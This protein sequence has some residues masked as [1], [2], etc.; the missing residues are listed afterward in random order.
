MSTL[1]VFIFKHHIEKGVKTKFQVAIAELPDGTP[2]NIPVMV[3]RGQR[4]GPT[5]CLSGAI[6]GDEY[7]GVAVISRLLKQLDPGELAGTV[8]GVPVMNPFAYYAEARL[9]KFD[10]E[11][12]NLN[13]IFPGNPDGD[14]GQ[15]MANKAFEGIFAHADFII[16]Y[17]EGGRDF[18]AKYMLVGGDIDKSS[19]VSQQAHQMARWFGHGVPVAVTYRTEVERRPGYSG[20][21]T[22][23]AGARGIPAIGVE[24]GGAGRVWEE[25]VSLGIAGTRNIMIGLG[26]LDGQMVETD[27][28]QV[29]CHVHSWP[30]PT[31]AGLLIPMPDSDRLGAIVEEGQVLALIYDPF[32]EVVEEI[33]GGGSHQG[34]RQPVFT[35]H[36][37]RNEPW[38]LEAM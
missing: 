14:L 4:S 13:R 22:G 36:A 19:D 12:Q 5:L 30:R 17:H 31:H 24:L 18:M 37:Q 3:A 6:H 23:A 2:I 10:Y 29:F 35:D 9:N 25:F 27:R 32:G 33:G 15:R 1:D 7:N 8:I 11:L 16:D 34:F 26:M 20:T 28:E 21:L 38:A